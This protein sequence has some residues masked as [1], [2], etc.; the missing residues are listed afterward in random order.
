MKTPLILCLSLSLTATVAIIAQDAKTKTTEKPAVAAPAKV[1]WV[2]LFNGKD[3]T[4]WTDASGGASKWVVAEGAMSGQKGS[5]DIWSKAR[6]ANFI[7]EV[8]FKTT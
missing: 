4:G 7:L 2:T 1:E 3:L 5:G 8:E 6:Y